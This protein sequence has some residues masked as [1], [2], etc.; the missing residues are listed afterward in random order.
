MKL[1]IKPRTGFFLNFLA[2]APNWWHNDLQQ[3]FNRLGIMKVTRNGAHYLVD[4]DGA[5]GEST[6]LFT[7]KIDACQQLD[8]DMTEVTSINSIGVKG[9]ITWTLRIPRGCKVRLLNCPYVIA[10]QASIV[11]GFTTSAIKIE[12]F[13]APFVCPNCNYEEIRVLTR[14]TDFEY[15]I[16]PKPRK[17]TMPQNLKCSKC[18]PGILEPDF[19]IEKTFKFL[20]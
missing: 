4:L 10:S 19:L 20:G 1:K 16:P 14:G 9:W 12:S 15:A 3:S 5:I 2:L 7:L 17:I 8:L 11:L 6:P 13:R 18:G